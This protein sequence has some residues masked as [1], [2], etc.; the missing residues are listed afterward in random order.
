MAIFFR[1][2]KV[3]LGGTTISFFALDLNLLTIDVPQDPDPDSDD[4]PF[5]FIAKMDGEK[6]ANCSWFKFFS[7]VSFVDIG[8]D[9]GDTVH[10]GDFMSIDDR[11]EKQ[12]S[13]VSAKWYI[14][15]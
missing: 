14:L 8:D 3:S 15:K 9:V 5:E 1:L 4:D 11:E 6:D 10:N 2:Q 7:K 12:L 13:L